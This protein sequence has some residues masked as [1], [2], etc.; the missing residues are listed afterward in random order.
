MF[1]VQCV[2]VGKPVVVVKMRNEQ[3]SD[4]KPGFFAIIHGRTYVNA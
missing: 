4:G 3:G 2:A 1:V